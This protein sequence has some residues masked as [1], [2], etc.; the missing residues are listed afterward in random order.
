MT[1]IIVIDPHPILRLGLVQLLKE[2]FTEAIVRAEDYATL[3]QAQNKIE[4]CDLILLT[5]SSQDPIC[6]YIERVTEVYNPRFILLSCGPCSKPFSAFHHQPLI[7]GLISKEANPELIKASVQL[8][9]AGG[10]CFPHLDNDSTDTT[11]KQHA[12]VLP[13]LA[14]PPIA[15]KSQSDLNE[16]QLLGLTNRQYEVLVL[17]AQGHPLKTVAKQLHISLGT[18]KSHTETLYQRLNVNNRNAAV[19]TAVARGATLGWNQNNPTP[20]SLSA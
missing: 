3:Q 10:T 1:T 12:A 2:K 5:L 19:Y 9:L 16:A 20:T 8:V 14:I 15:P 13:L 7:K 18:I 11:L 4:P 17:L 6:P